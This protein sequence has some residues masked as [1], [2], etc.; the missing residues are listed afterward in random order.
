MKYKVKWTPRRARIPFVF[1]VIIKWIQ[2]KP[3]LL[4]ANGVH[5]ID[6]SSGGG[7]T[8]LM[9]YIACH[10]VERGGFMWA[11]IDEFKNPRIKAFDIEKLYGNGDANYKLPKKIEKKIGDTTVTYYSKGIIYDELNRYFNRRMNKTRDYNDIF[12]PL[13]SDTVI[14]RH[15]GHPRIY[16]IGQS[17][18]MQDTQIAQ[19]AKYRHYVQA[20]FRWRYYFYRNELR[21]VYAPYKIK[22]TNFIKTGIDPKGEPIFK[23]MRHKL[24]IRIQASYLESY[25]TH[26]Y[27]DTVE[28]RPDYR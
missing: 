25:N 3:G 12:V 11:N 8:L 17:L 20:R 19:V 6:S 22:V 14:H 28:D 18:M 13:V 21:M 2:G 15:L 5:Y 4:Y 7:K 23:E 26:A 10:L 24:V 27:A 16:F 1:R 9:N